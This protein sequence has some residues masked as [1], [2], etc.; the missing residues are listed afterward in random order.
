MGGG[1]R[2]RTGT[3]S[4]RSSGSRPPIP[5]WDF[6]PPP[7]KHRT[8][9]RN[10]SK[11]P[12]ADFYCFGTLG[13]GARR[14]SPA[15]RS[16]ATILATRAVS[17]VGRAPA[18]QAGGHWFEPSTAHSPIEVRLRLRRSHDDFDRFRR[19]PAAVCEPARVR[20][21]EMLEPDPTRS[22]LARGNLTCAVAGVSVGARS[23]CR[24]K[25]GRCGRGALS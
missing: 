23:R 17:S 2:T 11:S 14:S 15:A 19:L 24:R 21:G 22:P 3:D 1:R 8:V 16:A 18:R 12:G 6:N 13:A 20:G 9:R 25:G 7:R 5:P 4:R 10:Y